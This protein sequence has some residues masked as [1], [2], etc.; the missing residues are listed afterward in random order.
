MHFISQINFILKRVILELCAGSA[1]R[2][3]YILIGFLRLNQ[4]SCSQS[5]ESPKGVGDGIQRILHNQE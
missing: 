1:V 2:K 5:V 4:I 3:V